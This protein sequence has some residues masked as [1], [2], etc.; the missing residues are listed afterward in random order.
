MIELIFSLLLTSTEL[1][2]KYEYCRKPNRCQMVNAVVYNTA[3]IRDQIQLFKPDLPTGI[4][5][6]INIKFAPNGGIT[7]ITALK[8]D[9]QYS[10]V[11]IKHIVSASPFQIVPEAY[12]HIKDMNLTFGQ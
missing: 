6:R 2:K 5:C 4:S 3:L 7:S 9:P 8:C 11:I 12:E 10:A 1:E